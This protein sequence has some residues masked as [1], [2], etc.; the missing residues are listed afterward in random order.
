MYQ[1]LA[2]ADGTISKI[3]Q[4]WLSELLKLSDI[5][6]KMPLLDEEKENN[7]F[8][9]EDS[10]LKDP[11]FK[12]A[13]RIIVNSDH[14]STSLLQRKLKLGYNRAGSIMDQLERVGIVGPFEGSKGREVLIKENIN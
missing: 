11:F 6:D 10:S 7:D 9:D 4:K 5:T 12:E 13:A 3:E 8:P 14:G 2:K 1:L